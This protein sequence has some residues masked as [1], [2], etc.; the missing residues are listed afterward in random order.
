MPNSEHFYPADIVFIA[1]GFLGPESEVLKQ[2]NVAQDARM[3]NIVTPAGRYSTSV[4]K[5]FAAGDCRRGQSLV[6]WGI[7]EGRMCA[8]DVDSFLEGVK[9][10]VVSPLPIT[11]G[12]DLP[13]TSILNL[14]SPNA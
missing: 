5:V 2:L 8:R 9:E 6:V 7:N 3:T 10:G 14:A 4:P 1:M 12:I 13:S 11:G